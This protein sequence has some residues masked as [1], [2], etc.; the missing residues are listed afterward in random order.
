MRLRGAPVDAR[1]GLL[2]GLAGFACFVLAPALGLPPKPPGAAVGELAARQ[3]WWFGAVLATA[4][5]LW[6]ISR[7]AW[8][9]RLLALVLLLLPHAIGAPP[10]AGADLVPPSLALRFAFTS[11]ATNLV[12]WLALGALCGALLGRLTPQVRGAM[13][14]TASSD[15]RLDVPRR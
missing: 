14:A 11:V 5:G 10:S 12:F 2:W 1:R 13:P 6:L 3:A 7:P 9:T 15:P 8:S 4:G